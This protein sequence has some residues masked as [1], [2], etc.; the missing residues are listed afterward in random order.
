M[1]LVPK[2][3][4][5]NKKE[6]SITIFQFSAKTDKFGC[7]R[8]WMRNTTFLTIWKSDTP[9]KSGAME[10][11][12][13]VRNVYCD[14]WCQDSAGKSSSVIGWLCAMAATGA[15][16]RDSGSGSVERK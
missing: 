2:C 3:Q 12:A 4:K 8:Q 5:K 1:N 9:D 13:R 7:T 15:G 14:W 6:I 10:T 16:I 11:S